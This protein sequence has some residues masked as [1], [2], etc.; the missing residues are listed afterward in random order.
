MALNVFFFGIVNW[1]CISY[2]PLSFKLSTIPVVRYRHLTQEMTVLDLRHLPGSS[3]VRVAKVNYTC[4][5]F[6]EKHSEGHYH[7]FSTTGRLGF[8][9][10]SNHSDELSV[11]RFVRWVFSHLGGSIQKAIEPVDQADEDDDDDGHSRLRRNVMDSWLS[12]AAFL[13]LFLS[14]T[15][16]KKFPAMS[17]QWHWEWTV[18]KKWWWLGFF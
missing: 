10:W 16:P 5:K 12:A 6:K 8:I 13:S 2:G 17:Q 4:L 1:Q 14:F 3:L 9:V 18:A 15:P 7:K 11:G